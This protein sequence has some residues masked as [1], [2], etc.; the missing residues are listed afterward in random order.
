MKIKFRNRRYHLLFS[1]FWSLFYQYDSL[2]ASHMH[3]DLFGLA[4]VP[5]EI[6]TSRHCRPAPAEFPDYYMSAIY[7]H[8]Y[9]GQAHIHVFLLVY[10]YTTEIETNIYWNIC[11][12]NYIICLRLLN[13]CFMKWKY[14][15]L[16]D[17]QLHIIMTLWRLQF[18]QKKLKKII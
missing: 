16:Q 2:H 7:F 9:Q 18:L 11:R 14:N 17:M 3:H 5:I 13:L 10:V 8:S 12:N 4:I 1:H 6:S 15:L